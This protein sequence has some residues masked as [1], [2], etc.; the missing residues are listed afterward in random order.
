MTTL[1]ERRLL[2]VYRQAVGQNHWA[3]AEHL[4]AA[5]EACAQD[6]AADLNDTLAEAYGVLARASHP[7]GRGRRGSGPLDLRLRTN[8]YSVVPC[9]RTET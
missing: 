5:I 8:V 9:S 3:A 1:L 2:S 6:D 4:L 7:G